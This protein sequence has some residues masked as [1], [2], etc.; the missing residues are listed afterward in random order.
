MVKHIPVIFWKAIMLFHFPQLLNCAANEV[1]H[2]TV[3]TSFACVY[4]LMGSRRREEKKM[5]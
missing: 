4:L 5:I 1:L 2:K 3:I